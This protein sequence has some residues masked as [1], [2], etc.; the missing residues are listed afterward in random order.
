MAEKT[1]N[2]RVIHKHDTESNWQNTEFVP[3][4]GEVIIYDRD[5][6]T[7][8]ERVKIGDG[9]SIVNNLPFL[10]DGVKTVLKE[11][12]LIVTYQ[13]SSKMKITHT[14]AQIN[15]AVNNGRTVFFQKD[16]EL[17]SL[18]EITN[19]YATFYICY[20]NMNGKLQQKVVAVS[21]DSIM[22][23]QDDTYDYVLS[24][25]FTNTL[26]NYSTKTDLNNYYTKTETENYVDSAI[27]IITL[28][29]IDAICDGTVNS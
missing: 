9:V 8:Y 27:E 26:K 23:E 2:S 10:T 17:L 28:E 25:T 7:P 13:P 18:L 24:K 6:A 3:K 1:I 5:D 21:G 19:S 12:D 15:E 29:A 14:I 22:L 11:K 4:K 20:I 16:A